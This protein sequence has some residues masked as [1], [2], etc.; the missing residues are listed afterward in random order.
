MKQGGHTVATGKHKGPNSRSNQQLHSVLLTLGL[1]L[2]I[3]ALGVGGG[4]LLDRQVLLR[5]D[6]CPYIPDDASESFQLKA[7]AWR[8]IEREFVSPD[9]V[10]AQQMTYGAIRG[11]VI[12]LDDPGHTRFLAPEEL[13]RHRQFTAGQFEGIGAEVE[14]RDD[15]PVIVSTLEGSPAEHAGLAEGDVILEVDGEEVTGLPLH[16]V[17]T[18]VSG[19]A[20]TEVTLVIEAAETGEVREVTLTRVEI[21]LDRV[22]WA[23][24]SETEVAHV[25]I[26]A[27]SSGVAET[28][29]DMLDEIEAEIEMRAL[30][31]DLRDNSGG[32]L[33]EA[34]GV[35][36]LFVE[37]GTVV[38]R[39]DAQGDVSETSVLEDV[40]A[41]P[42]PPPSHTVVLVNART[43]SA[44]EVVAGALQ[45]HGR[46]TLVGT[47]TSGA[48]TV[49]HEFELADGS[50]LLLAVEE[51]RTPEGRTIW[52]EG[53]NPDVEI[54]LP[55]DVTPAFPVQ[56]DAL[57]FQQ[58]QEGPDSQLIRALEL[59]SA[60]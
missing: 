34:I 15:Q 48:G 47:P 45:D 49:L 6:P 11:M 51:W 20:G 8:T 42:S 25:R 31:L 40:E 2:L 57:T 26:S 38:R 19:P 7:E 60:P 56:T 18:R 58:L 24:L 27:F 4:V 22:T 23:H 16:Q 32:L 59:V 12:T 43:A 41:R 37:S 35:T 28:L 53:L 1:L 17:V 14:I 29:L 44:A 36:S 55:P 46:A 13:R 21:E 52:R 33:S 54:T 50:A 30:I 3:L 39:I 10:D 5:R 9:D